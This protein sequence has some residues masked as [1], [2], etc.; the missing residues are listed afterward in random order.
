VSESPVPV[1][2]QRS[3]I[4]ATPLAEETGGGIN[5]GTILLIIILVMAL[6]AGAVVF[7]AWRGRIRE[8]E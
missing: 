4:V 3:T 7:L 1:P 6:G 2:T 8:E 5:F